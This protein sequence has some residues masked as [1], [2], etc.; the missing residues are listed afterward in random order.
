MIL[1]EKENRKIVKQTF[2]MAWPAVVESFFIA[3][4]G[5]VDSLMV[6]S[7]GAYAVAAVGLTAQPK[8]IGLAIFIATNVAVSALVARRKGQKDRK[9]ANEIFLFALAFSILVGIVVSIACVVFA[10][11]IIALCG[12]NQD[13][14]ET[15]V[16]YFQIV[17]G[18]ILFSIISLVINA[19]QRGAGKTKIAMTTNLTSNIINLFFNYLLIGGNLGFPKLGVRGSAIATVIGTV[20]AC[21]M[22]LWSLRK[23]D[24]FIS[25]PYILEEKLRPTLNQGRNIFKIGSNIFVEQIFLRIGFMSVAVMA[26]KLGTQEFAAHQ[27]AMNVMGISFSFG[28][29]MQV[30]AVAL[31]GRS[32]GEQK[33]ELAKMYGTICRRIGY[34]ISA[35]LSVIYLVSGKWLY[36]L[37]FKEPEIVAIGVKIMQIMVIIVILQIAQV[38]YMGCLRGAGDVLFT[39]ITSTISVTIMRPVAAY[40]LGYVL[41]FGVVGIWMGVVADQ[42][43]R[44][45]LTSWRFGTGKWIT[46]EI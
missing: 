24:N 4:A 12:A 41:G 21:G 8:Y 30:A 44:Y 27:V 7:V 39:T 43:L 2:N 17:M 37:Y 22:S 10:N 9:S 25:I 5:L 34:I 20:V 28:D 18:G 45:L 11:P 3:L 19:A 14:H 38:I 32:L 16:E 13:T 36:Q 6:S 31:I 42:L 40:L 35:F 46:R 1:F 23:T 26:A 15:S 33:P 29:G